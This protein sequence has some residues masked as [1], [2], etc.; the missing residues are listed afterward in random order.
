LAPAAKQMGSYVGHLIAEDVGGRSRE[1]PA[2]I[3]HHQ[4]DLATIE[5]K[6]AVVSLPWIKLKGFVGWLFWGVAHIY[7][8]IGIRNRAIVTLN[9]MWEYVTFQRGAR[10]ING[11]SG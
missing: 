1:V 9:W 11:S 4:G 7:F 3:Y 5:R 8:L 6:S 2:F 10:I